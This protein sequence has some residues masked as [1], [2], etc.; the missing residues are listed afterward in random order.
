MAEG[1]MTAKLKA[2]Q[3][4]TEVEAECRPQMPAARGPNGGHMQVCPL[5]GTA[6]LGEVHEPPPDSPNSFTQS[7]VTL[8][9][10]IIVLKVW[11]PVVNKGTHAHPN[12]WPSPGATTIDLDTYSK[13]SVLLEGEHNLTLPCIGSEQH[14]PPCTPHSFPFSPLLNTHA[15]STAPGEGT[16]SI[17]HAADPHLKV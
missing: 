10:G 7:S 2:L 17:R 9:L 12:P 3:H 5:R 11:R 14:A 13:A 6:P 15:H 8:E 1:A 4:R 16:A